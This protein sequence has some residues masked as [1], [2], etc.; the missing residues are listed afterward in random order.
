MRGGWALFIMVAVLLLAGAGRLVYLEEA[1]G[2]QRRAQASEQ[3]VQEWS[4]PAR[5]GDIVD[6]RGRVLVGSTRRPSVFVD[7]SLIEEPL[8]A[9]ELVAPALQEDPARIEAAIRNP[10]FPQFTWIKRELTNEQLAAFRAVRNEHELWAFVVRYEDKRIYPFGPLAAQVLGRVGVDQQGLCGVEGEFEKLLAGKSGKAKA[11]VDV[12]RRRV[13]SEP[14]EYEPPVDG[15]NVVLTLDARIQQRTEYHLAKAFE[16]WKPT[17]ATAVVMDPL[18]GEVLAMAT[19]PSFDPATPLPPDLT[20]QDAAVL[21]ETWRNRAISDAF[22]PGSIFKVFVGAAAFDEGLVS[23]D[24][25]FKINGPIHFFGR[26]RIRDTHEYGTLAFYEVISKS[27]NIGM[28]LLGDRCGNDRLHEYVRRFGFGRLGGVQLPGENAGLVWPRKM[29][30]DYSTHSIPI[31][32]EISVTSLQIVTGF[33]ALCNT[34]VLYR[35]RIVRGVTS[36][37]GQV[38]QDNSSAVEVEWVLSTD[39]VRTFRDRALAEVVRSGTGQR[40]ALEDYQVFGKTGTAQIAKDPKTEGE[41]YKEGAY[42]GSFVGGAPVENPRVAVVVSMYHPSTGKY[43]GGTVSAPTVAAIIA[44]TL[45]YMGVAPSEP[46]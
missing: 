33:S 18:S 21:L 14:D 6:C 39:K 45:D 38:V 12:R 40:A 37:D 11:I 19:L 41:G 7:P 1:Q 32:Q 35:P 25:I 8:L 5:R 24:E 29:W 43:Y 2:S 16:Q 28:G 9:A 22:E 10:Q 17:W 23:L 30:R 27:S 46:R 20:E 42:V 36:M 13:R 3:Q 44:D 4:I 31:G 26:Q 15:A 34:G